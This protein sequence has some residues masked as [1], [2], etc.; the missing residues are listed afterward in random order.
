MLKNGKTVS[1]IAT[2]RPA[3]AKAFYRDVLRLPLLSA[4]RFAVVFA[5]REGTLRVT[6][7]DALAPAPF[8]VLG[9]EVE[10]IREEAKVLGEFGV[11][12][13]RFPGLEQDE[14]GIWTAPGGAKVAW[15]KDPD[16]NVLSLTE[17]S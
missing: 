8:T 17:P 6:E 1:F 5:L 3:E 9:W 12:F 2:V 14:Q 13:A 10:N 7:V 11:E 16:G 15:F 4:D